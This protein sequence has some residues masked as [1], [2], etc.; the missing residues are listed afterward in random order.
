MITTYSL[1]GII[2][3]VRI[4]AKNNCYFIMEMSIFFMAFS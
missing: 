1:S 2:V 3:I 4:L